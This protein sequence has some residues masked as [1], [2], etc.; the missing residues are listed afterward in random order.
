[1]DKLA[2]IQG[3]E[4][5]GLD[6]RMHSTMVVGRVQYYE[7]DWVNSGQFYDWKE[8]DIMWP[9]QWG[10]YQSVFFLNVPIVLRE[11][12]IWIAI[13]VNIC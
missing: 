2:T 13:T 7:G 4:G 12:Y 3:V 1:M 9:R 5:K 8:G 10:C 11:C 6:G